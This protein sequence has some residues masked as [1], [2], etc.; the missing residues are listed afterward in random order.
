MPVAH[1]RFDADYWAANLRN[2]VRFADAITTAGAS[3]GTFIEI[4][5]HPLLTHAIT[6][7]LDTAVVTSAMNRDQDQT[8]FFHAQL[9]AVGA[10]PS[11]ATAGRL[12]DIPH[13]P[14]HHSTVLGR[15]PIG[16][17]RS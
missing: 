10:T 4:S 2:P 6:D 3:H 12:A 14:W 5:P 9:A 15:G 1:R 16:H 13:A 8:L 11:G 17:G 7:T